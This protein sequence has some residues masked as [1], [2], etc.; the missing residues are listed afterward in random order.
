VRA[1]AKRDPGVVAGILAIEWIRP[2]YAGF[3]T[4]TWKSRF[5][6]AKRFSCKPESL[7]K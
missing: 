7:R 1:I 6:P 4:A 3:D 2:F 5:N